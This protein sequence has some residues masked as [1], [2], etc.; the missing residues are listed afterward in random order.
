MEQQFSLS[1]LF[2]AVWRFKWMILLVVIIAGGTAFVLTGQQVRQYQAV[3]TIM[4]E[5]GQQRL[6]A[7]PAD[8][9]GNLEMTYLQDVASQIEVM[10]SH[11]VV[12][13]AI[14]ELEPDYANNPDLLES[15]VETLQAAFSVQQV[16]NT[17]MV[18]L[19]VV[20]TDSNLAQAQANA[21]A[22]AYIKAAHD[23]TVT[24]MENAL[25]DTTKRLAD[26][27]KNNANLS[28]SPLLTQLNAQI[29]TALPALQAVSDGLQELGKGPVASKDAGTT[30]ISS[31][32]VNA[33]ERINSTSAD[34]NKIDE[35][36]KKI[37]YVSE[38]SDFAA[39]SAD[40][41]V[42]EGALRALNIK[43]SSLSSDISA[44]Q[45]NEIDLQV[46][47]E[48][49][50]VEEQIQV[51]NVTAGAIL[52][53][54]VSLY[55]IQQQYS[56]S[57]SNSSSTPEQIAQYKEAD[58]N[59]LSRI[60]GHSA[61]LLTSQVDQVNA[62]ISSMIG[63]LQSLSQKLQPNTPGGDVLLSYDE[64]YAMELSARTF[65]VNLA[66]LSS[67]IENIPAD[68]LDAQ[69]S[70]ILLN[71]QQSLN[72]TSSA[73]AGVGD[74]I[75]SLIV[76]GGDTTSYNVLEGLRQ[77]L[78]LMLLESDTGKSRIVDTAIVFLATNA[79]SRNKNMIIAIIAGLLL[80]IF[81]AVVL[82]YFDRTIRDA[83]QV[84]NYTGLPFLASLARVKGGNPHTPTV[85]DKQLP[86]YLE[87][88]RLLRTNLG[89]DDYQGKVL[90]VSS[91]EAKEGKTTVAINLARSVA[92]QG[93]KVLL[94]DA[95]LRK[96]GIA[97]V[98]DLPEGKGLSDSLTTEEEPLGH[99]NQVDGIDVLTAGDGS[100]LPAEILCSPR[101]NMLLNSAR[102]IYD[103][104]IIDSAPI[105][106]YADTRILAKEVDWVL[107]VLKPDTSR[108]DLVS[109][110]K[111]VLEN[112]GAHI[113]GF[114]LNKTQPAVGS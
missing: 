16:G 62:R 85:L 8:N 92:I 53:Q 13:A 82:Q 97:S 36:T 9:G 69:D 71:V 24:T 98:L 112:I 56:I 46:K 100:A 104:I 96:P 108:L 35:L 88:F 48:I 39:R 58:K 93:R 43:L 59:M 109:E 64:L 113:A 65:S 14:L 52:D 10:K 57:R 3:T 18:A 73:T 20:S 91:P 79:S 4:V 7:F 107:L 99:L 6:A 22:N 30:L 2:K 15:Q 72:T 80:S 1:K 103:V 28:I 55:S 86:Q 29:G 75:S 25:S 27:R 101:L 11:S 38:T 111:Q 17:N 83:S 49:T 32:L 110:S 87:S 37:N 26:L 68:Q 12:E 19:K 54:I 51:A 66:S 21:I 114:V 31:Q 44:M 63:T 102:K 81:V 60:G 47:E 77:Q 106:G 70:T 5:G 90:L 50:G 34:I 74:E 94:I 61:L 76:S 23:A 40:I 78:Q 89:I 42:V 33:E 84:K 45:R 105:L 95:N 41:A 67:E